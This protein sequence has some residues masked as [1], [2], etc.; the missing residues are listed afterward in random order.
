MT[1]ESLL[2]RCEPHDIFIVPSVKARHSSL[3]FH[4][5]NIL[6]F[7]RIKCPLGKVRGCFDLRD[8][9]FPALNQLVS[10]AHNSWR[11]L[12][13][14]QFGPNVP[15]RAA[16][17][18]FYRLFK[19]L[20][21]VFFIFCVGFVVNLFTW[22]NAPVP[23]CMKFAVLNREEVARL[24]SVNTSIRRSLHFRSLG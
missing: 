9:N 17:R 13:A 14:A 22:I 8:R 21:K 1:L 23:A 20:Q 12:P 15:V 24:D 2:W 7:V 19:K 16:T 6:A 18:S 3:L 5:P 10:Y 11:A 4:P